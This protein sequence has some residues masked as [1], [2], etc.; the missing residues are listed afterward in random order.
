MKK[1]KNKNTYINKNKMKSQNKFTKLKF[2]VKLLGS[3]IYF[4]IQ[5]KIKKHK[6]NK[7]KHIFTFFY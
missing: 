3:T 7:E 2:T 4:L 5:Y 1:E 6:K